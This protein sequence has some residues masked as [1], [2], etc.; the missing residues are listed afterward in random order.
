[1]T[2]AEAI[3][4]V[5]HA[6]ASGITFVDTSNS[7]GAGRSERL[8]GE[9]LARAG[10]PM[11]EVIVATKVDPEPGPRV[12]APGE[13]SFTGERVR[14]SAEESLERLGFDH[15]PVLYL[16]DPELFPFDDLTAPGGAVDALVELKQ[17]GIASRIGVAGGD[18]AELMRYLELGVFDLLL[19]HNRFTL[20]NRA[21]EPLMRK[22]QSMNLPFINAAPFGGGILAKG[23][24]AVPRYKYEP[25]PAML[26]ATVS[27]MHEASERHGVP[28]R[29]AALQFSLKQPLISS[30]VVG[31]SRAERVSSVL[32]DATAP[33]PEDLW[34]ELEAIAAPWLESAETRL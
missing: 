29:V 4:V 23:E 27:A 22:A 30:T 17:T 18:P 12:F 21:A 6:I 1:V 3:S 15:F 14:R 9:A 33:V 26:R 11:D 19:N 28:L 10:R 25:A 20:V 5:L 24:R 2:D 32:R 7:Y 8:V 31:M 16:H 13:R 34:I